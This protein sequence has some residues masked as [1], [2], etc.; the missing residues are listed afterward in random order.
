MQ[1]TLRIEQKMAIANNKTQQTESSVE[2][3]LNSVADEQQRADSFRVVEIMQRASGEPPK[4]WGPS[5]VGFGQ[6]HLLYDSGREMDW[7]IVGFSPRKN[8]LVLYG[9][10]G[11]G[12]QD[13]LGQLGKHSTGKGCLYLKR[14]SDIDEIVLE[15]MVGSSVK[16]IGKAG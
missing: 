4:M 10:L 2:D 3:F 13:D 12:A 8:R 14:L 1:K 16:R 9:L 15:K 7:M 11:E 5:I 6:R